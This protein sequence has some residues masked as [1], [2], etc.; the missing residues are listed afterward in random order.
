MEISGIGATMPFNYLTN[1]KGQ[2][3]NKPQLPEDTVE[4]Q[5][6]NIPNDEEAEIIYNDTLAMLASDNGAALSVHSGLSES[7]VFELLGM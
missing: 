2:A 7:R 4:L 6:L 1:E 3:S 5:G